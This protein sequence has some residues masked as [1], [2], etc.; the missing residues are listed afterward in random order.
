MRYSKYQ[1]IGIGLHVLND[2]T[3]LTN[4][5]PIKMHSQMD[6]S[7]YDASDQQKLCIYDV[8]EPTPYIP[9]CAS[10]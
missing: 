2:K 7:A 10:H 6:L 8:P 1:Q 3:S 9:F 5:S 4:N